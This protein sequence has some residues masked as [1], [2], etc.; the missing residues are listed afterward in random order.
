M[1]PQLFVLLAFVSMLGV[2]SCGN[3][4]YDKAIAD[5]DSLFEKKDYMGAKS[6]YTKALKILP[7][8]EYPK[9]QLGKVEG[10]LAEIAK[11]KAIEDEKVYNGLIEKA[12]KLFANK[13]LAGAREVYQN[14]SAVKPAETYPKNRIA[15]ITKIL[16]EEANMKNYPYH[17]VI[18]CFEV[19]K[20]A[21][22]YL[23]KVQGEHSSNAHSMPLG[24]FDAVI[25][26]SYKTMREAYNDLPKGK[27]I[28]GEAW[29]LRK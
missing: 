10:F 26:K 25:Y 11:Q 9:A 8:E 22:R 20:N 1:K 24:R 5:A 14:A 23:A 3:A 7:D 12:D 27:E 21:E 4:E 6:E 2:L 17:L 19:D 15:E 29:V 18:G 16:E 28:A 13:D